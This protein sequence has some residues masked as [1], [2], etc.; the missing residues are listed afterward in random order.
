MTC[1]PPTC[2]RLLE[3]IAI[4]QDSGIKGA[5]KQSIREECRGC[6]NRGR[7]TASVI[8]GELTQR[9]EVSYPKVNV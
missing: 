7:K 5:V 3:R 2:Y 4:K 6:Q 1:T 9:K 8:E